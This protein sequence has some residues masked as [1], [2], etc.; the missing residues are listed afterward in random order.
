MYRG[1]GLSLDVTEEF[2]SPVSED[3]CI[4]LT[5][6]CRP[7]TGFIDGLIIFLPVL[8]PSVHKAGDT[9]PVCAQ[10][11]PG[12][13]QHSSTSL[14]RMPPTS[15]VGAAVSVELT[16]SGAELQIR[17]ISQKAVNLKEFSGL[18]GCFC[19]FVQSK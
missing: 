8:C 17:S 9:P 10:P 13:D 15:K 14:G 11:G 16:Q 3:T 6:H 7:G 5:V 18:F 2:K 19:F 1:V 4:S 12:W